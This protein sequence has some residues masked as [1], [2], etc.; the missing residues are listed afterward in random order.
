MS[1][2]TT[3]SLSARFDADSYHARPKDLIRW[4]TATGQRPCDECAALQ[5]ETHGTHPR[6]PARHRR[7]ITEGPDLLLCHP[8]AEAW[9]DRD[10]YDLN[11]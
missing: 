9:K 3:D 11:P 1:T 10:A 8:H 5:H 6:K 2:P 4:T 7:A